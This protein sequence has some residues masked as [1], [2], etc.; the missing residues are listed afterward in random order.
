M[1]ESGEIKGCKAPSTPPD[2]SA[3][4]AG[5][6]R[7]QVTPQGILRF[8]RATNAYLMLTDSEWQFDSIRRLLI[9]LSDPCQVAG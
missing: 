8:A 1:E 3:V 4:A 7:Q 5:F 6:L 9:F 2:Y